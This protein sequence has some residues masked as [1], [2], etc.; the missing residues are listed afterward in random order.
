MQF[1]GSRYNDYIYINEHL[2]ITSTSQSISTAFT[3][4]ISRLALTM[5]KFER[6]REMVAV[7]LF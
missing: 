5:F 2:D 7:P 4:L 3:R 1:N 6:E